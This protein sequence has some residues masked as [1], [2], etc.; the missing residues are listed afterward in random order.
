MDTQTRR[1]SLFAMLDRELIAQTGQSIREWACDR[2]V[3]L[4]LV[5]S[6]LQC[7]TTGDNV[8]LQELAN[9]L[10][11]SVSSIRKWCV[12]YRIAA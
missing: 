4:N 2:C 6:S 3:P 7:E 9:T 10:R 12:E 5:T 1:I 11:I 8:V